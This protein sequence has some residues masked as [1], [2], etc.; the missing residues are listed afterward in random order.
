MKLA[1]LRGRH[2]AHLKVR[3]KSVLLLPTEQ[4]QAFFLPAMSKGL[5][6][7]KELLQVREADAASSGDGGGS[8]SARFMKAFRFFEF[9]RDEGWR[10]TV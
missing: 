7:V 2:G 4:I 1:H 5:K 8:L 6:C 3:G 10:D 9:L